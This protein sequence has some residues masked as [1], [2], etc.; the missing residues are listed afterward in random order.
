MQVAGVVLTGLFGLFIGGSGIGAGGLLAYSIIHVRKKKIPVLVSAAVGT[1]TA[2]IV[3]EIFPESV[4]TGGLLI[5]LTGAFAGYGLTRKMDQFFHQVFIITNNPQQELLLQSGMLLAFAVGLH[6]FPT[7]IALG[8]SLMNSPQIAQNVSIAM[9]IHS[10]PEGLALGLPLALSK[11]R[12]LAILITA[13][14][15]A[16]PTG[17]GASLG[18]IFGN[19]F[20]S[21]LSF[22][23]GIA[24]GTMIYVT[25]FEILRP[26]WKESGAQ[27]GSVGF[28]VGWALGIVFIS[29]M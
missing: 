27:R 24:I 15:V 25:F 10:I 12:P 19:I 7:G 13:G 3:L 28:F 21:A 5:T 11:I 22:M 26:A 16:I 6:N 29:I 8:S 14:I 1:I 17:L 9:V 23:L 18:Y 4:E 2:F 20:P